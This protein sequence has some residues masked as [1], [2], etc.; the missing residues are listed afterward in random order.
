MVSNGQFTYIEVKQIN[1][2]NRSLGQQIGLA[3]RRTITTELSEG[4]ETITT[5]PRFT[6][7]HETLSDLSIA[8]SLR[9]F[10]LDKYINHLVPMWQMCRKLAKHGHKRSDLQKLQSHS[11]LNSK[12]SR[13]VAALNERQNMQTTLF[14]GRLPNQPDD[15]AL[16]EALSRRSIEKPPWW[17]DTLSMV[18]PNVDQAAFFKSY[19]QSLF[20]AYKSVQKKALMREAEELSLRCYRVARRLSCSRSSNKE[21]LARHR[22]CSVALSLVSLLVGG[23]PNPS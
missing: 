7:L 22:M 12:L 20:T 8:S 19:A 4:A 2:P 14:S 23:H 1:N 9:L 5:L 3:L 16:K 18:D 13:S 21:Y 6:L 11:K 10:L 17:D 15:D